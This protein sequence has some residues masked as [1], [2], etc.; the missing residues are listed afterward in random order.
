MRIFIFGL[1]VAAA[2]LLKA[3]SGI[4]HEDY[5]NKPNITWKADRP[6]QYQ[7][8]KGNPGHQN[9]AAMTA[10]AIEVSYEIKAGKVNAEVNARF[11]PED[12]WMKKH[13]RTAR[14][15]AHEQLHFDI[16]EWHARKLRKSLEGARFK[17]NEVEKVQELIRSHYVAWQASQKAY[18]SETRHGLNL[19]KQA[20]WEKQVKNGLNTLKN[21]S[22]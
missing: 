9:L 2:F 7:D 17:E 18:D 16:T 14:I 1:V 6:L 20:K 8:F 5:A 13:A 3:F 11:Y 15:L 19:D 22:Y 12:S 21:Y 10:S 4:N